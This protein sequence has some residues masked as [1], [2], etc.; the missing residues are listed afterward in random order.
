MHSSFY[1]NAV[2]DLILSS[3]LSMMWKNTYGVLVG[4]EAK[5]G[6]CKVVFLTKKLELSSSAIFEFEE[7]ELLLPE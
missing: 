3:P 6:N 7:E 5:A 4:V 1:F 2:L